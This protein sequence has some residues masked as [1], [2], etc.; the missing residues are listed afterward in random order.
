M[1]RAAGLLA[2]VAVLA[3]CGGAGAKG[4]ASVWVTRDR[5]THVLLVRRVPAGETAMQALQRVAKVKTRYG[6]RFVQAID[7]LG[8]S[9]SAQRDWFYFVNGYEAD[10]SAAEYVLHPGDVEWWDYRSWGES[11]EVKVVVGSFPEPFVHGYA[12]KRRP[13][14]VFGP[15]AGGRKLASYVHGSYAGRAGPVSP[16]ANTL[17]LREGPTSFVAR[18]G[19]AGGAVTFVYRGDWHV[20][21]QGRFRYRYRWP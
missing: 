18:G 12:G 1:R 21:L 5:G 15:P 10:R 14:V 17:V 19:R 11:P 6:G 13:A 9:L 7:G 2:A 20:L 16:A 3:G 4:T 8:G